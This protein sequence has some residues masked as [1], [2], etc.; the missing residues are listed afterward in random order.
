MTKCELNFIVQPKHTNAVGTLFGG[1]M[2][3]RMDTCAAIASRRLFTSNEFDHIVTMHV[4]VDFKKP[5]VVG[6]VVTM[7]GEIVNLGKSSIKINIKA[8]KETESGTIE[9]MGTGIFI[10]CTVKDG[11]P[12]PHG[13]KVK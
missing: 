4:E 6:D 10:M 13:L 12:Y 2:L 7:Y 11:K 8:T 5:A 9:T 1:E 3:S